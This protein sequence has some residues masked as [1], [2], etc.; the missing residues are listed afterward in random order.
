MILLLAVDSG[1]SKCEAICVDPG[2]NLVG[3]AHR[4]F[5]TV[6][7]ARF[8]GGLGRSERLVADTI[9]AALPDPLNAAELHVCG[10]LPNPLVPELRQVQSIAHH[11]VLEKDG[12][13]ALV[14]TRAG[15]VVLSGTGAF[16]YGRRHDGQEI[17]FDGLGPL[18]GDYGSGFQI[19]LAG[20]RAA[21]RSSWGHRHETALT[22]PILEAC[23]DQSGMGS[24]FNMMAYMADIRDRSEIASLARIVDRVADE[25]DS[26][27]ISIIR[28]AAA[29]MAE[30]VRCVVN[31]LD[32]AQADLPLIGTGSVATNSRRYWTEL[33]E[34]VLT[35][36][37]GLKPN[38]PKVPAVFG[39][40]LALA[41]QV[42]V[43][44]PEFRAN[45][46]AHAKAR[47]SFP[48][49]ESHH[50]STIRPKNS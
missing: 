38:L 43:N 48:T 28:R 47:S 44:S 10:P 30:T 36:A 41:D 37:P 34:C 24:E 19:G 4:D 17:L 12:P 27:A 18:Y 50:V 6:S 1:G 11:V 31:H 13:L 46:L 23:R 14:D 7:G 21:G 26:T 16:A 42:G 40:G 33:T 39:L 2:G 45:L 15:I 8:I 9:R 35:F 32:V 20:I 25:G 5:R 3:R 29:D 49:N 22:M